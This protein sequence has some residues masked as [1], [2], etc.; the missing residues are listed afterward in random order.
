MF[1]ILIRFLGL[2]AFWLFVIF[3]LIGAVGMVLKIGG[4]HLST[5]DAMLIGTLMYKFWW[6]VPAAVVAHMVWKA[7][8]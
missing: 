3:N 2:S 8:K 1:D 7:K 5:L 4:V 6:I